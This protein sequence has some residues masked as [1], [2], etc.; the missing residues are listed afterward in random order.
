MNAGVSAA[1]A[2]ARRRLEQQEEEERTSYTPHELT[3]GWEFKIV[4]SSTGA[5]KSDASLRSVLDEEQRSGWTLVEKF[6][7]GR[8]RLKRPATARANDSMLGADAYRTHVGMSELRLGLCIGA[9]VLCGIALIVGII[10]AFLTSG[11]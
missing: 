4:R 1:A 11:R 7:N 6:D 3:E 9:A 5:F 10:A 8:I 2:A